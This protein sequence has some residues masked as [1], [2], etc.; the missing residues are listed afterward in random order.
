MD[1][2]YTTSLSYAELTRWCEQKAEQHSRYVRLS[3]L[4]QSFE[5]RQLWCLTV[6][7]WETGSDLDRSALWVDGNLHASELAGTTACLMLIDELLAQPE[8]L[9]RVAFY[10]VPRLCPD[11]AELCLAGNPRYLRS[12]TRPYPFEDPVGSGIESSDIDDNGKVLWMRIPDANGPWKACPEEP[13]LLVRRAPE[14]RQGAFYRLLPEGH[15]VGPYEGHKIQPAPSRQGLDLNRNFPYKWRPQHEQ[16][17]A[18]DFPASEPEVAAAVRFL[19]AHRN[20]C[21]AVTFHTF[22]GVFLRPYSTLADDTMPKADL[23]AYTYFGK[24]GSEWS[25]YPVVCVY[26]DF[27]YHPKEVITGTF[28]DWIYEMLGAFAWTVEIWSVLRQAGITSG[29]DCQAKR[30]EYRFIRWFED[31]PVE[32][33]RQLL[34]FCEEQLDGQGFVDWQPFQH[35]TLG[36]VEIGGWDMF[37]LFRNPPPQFLEGELRPLTRWVR[38]LAEANP[39]LELVES[40]VNR[41]GDGLFQLRLIVDNAGWLPTYGSRK[42]LEREAVRGLVVRLSGECEF[43]SGQPELQLGHLEGMIS[44]PNCPL[45]H[46]GDAHDQRLVVEWVVRSSASVLQW[47]LSHERAGKLSGQF[48]LES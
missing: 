24:R 28:D 46:K 32:E 16:S 43:V 30:G 27:R 17:G 29:L 7:D 14:D 37:Y 44:R 42:A 4:G 25:G 11:G 9:E 1:S 12:S 13:R 23:E 3:S 47:Q 20:V 38:W 45:W 21:Q 8:L 40:S 41:L 33:E 2:G 18:G 5:G 6:T 22:S 19:S 34:K 36:A 35:P 10:V 15:W 31:H 26:H 48:G 39:R